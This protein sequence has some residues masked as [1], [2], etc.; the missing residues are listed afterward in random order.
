MI[1]DDQKPEIV[2]PTNWE[3]KIIG[4]DIDEMLKAVAES[5]EG[6]EYK[7]SPSNVSRGGKYYSLNVMLIVPTEYVRDLIFQNLS[8]HQAIKVVI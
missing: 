2:Y 8:G 1:I 4:S 5:I 6:I 7:V 3:Y